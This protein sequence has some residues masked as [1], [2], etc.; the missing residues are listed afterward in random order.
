MFKRIYTPL[1]IIDSFFVEKSEMYFIPHFFE[2][3]FNLLL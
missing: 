2:L 3:F 1:K